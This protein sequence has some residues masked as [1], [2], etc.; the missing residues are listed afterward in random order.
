M[1]QHLHGVVCM[2]P[3]SLDRQGRAHCALHSSPQLQRT[4]S[5]CWDGRE[6]KYDPLVPSAT[7]WRLVI[8]GSGVGRVVVP[9]GGI[10]GGER[11][12]AALLVEGSLCAEYFT[13]RDMLYGQYHVC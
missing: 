13:V 9:A 1:L 8:A 5:A 2:L 7:G 12:N 4:L 6:G 3:C 11:D 10:P